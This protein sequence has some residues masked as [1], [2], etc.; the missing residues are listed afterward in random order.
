MIAFS[1]GNVSP[2]FSTVA[3]SLGAAKNIFTVIDRKSAID[4]SSATGKTIASSELVG[5][6]EFKNVSFHYP[7]RPDIT[8]LKDFS[9]K[10]EPNQTV[11]LVGSSGS[12][13]STI[14]GLLE[15]FYDPIEGEI[16]ID[17]VPLKEWNLKTLRGLIGFVGQEPVLFQNTSVYKSCFDVKL[18]FKHQKINFKFGHFSGQIGHYK[19][20]D[21]GQN[22]LI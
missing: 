1:I 14:V 7:S 3:S 2:Y 21:N 20:R 18:C 6:I 5:T 8:V 19:R 13:K 9:L 4:P 12:G 16:L 11:A 15:R 17:G 22:I 10:I